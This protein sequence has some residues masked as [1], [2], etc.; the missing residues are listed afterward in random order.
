MTNYE[1]VSLF[2]L[3]M[4]LRWFVMLYESEIVEEEVF[5]RWREDLNENYPGKG[6]ALFQVNT[7]LTYLEEA[8][9]SEEDEDEDEEDS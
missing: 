7:W 8:E 6:Q 2:Q 9:E 4:V 5:L 1:L 3:G